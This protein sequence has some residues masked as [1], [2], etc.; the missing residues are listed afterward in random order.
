MWHP[1]Y[2]S[3]SKRQSFRFKLG[4]NVIYVASKVHKYGT[5][6][7]IDNFIYW[8]YARN[9]YGAIFS[10]IQYKVCQLRSSSYA[11]DRQTFQM[12]LTELWRTG[13]WESTHWQYDAKLSCSNMMHNLVWTKNKKKSDL[14]RPWTRHAN[15]YLE[16]TI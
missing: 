1:K 8:L 12:I 11:S 7:S 10:M 16:A 14:P 15:R 9:L 3:A 2:F 6:R 4:I 13:V 5:S